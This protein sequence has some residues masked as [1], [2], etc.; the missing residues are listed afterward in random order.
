MTEPAQT[1]APEDESA[2]LAAVVH[3][4]RIT[5]ALAV[6]AALAYVVPGL[7]RFRIWAPGEPP[8][9]AG[10]FQ[11]RSAEL[12]GLAGSSV[13]SE[14]TTRQR[15]REELGE[16]VAS[17][18]GGDAEPTSARE[19]PL[20]SVNPSEYEGITQRIEDPTGRGMRPFYE[21][22]TATAE[23]RE[24]A[25]TRVAHYGDSSIATDLITHTVR[26]R[27]QQR[28]GDGGHGFVLIARGY[29][30][31]RHRDLTHVT[32]GNWRVYEVTRAMLG[33]GHYGYG[34]IAVRG[35]SG[36]RA[37]FGT[38][39][40]APVGTRVSR[41]DLYYRAHQRGGRAELRVDGGEPRL[42]DTA[43]ETTEDRV[44]SVTVPDGAHELELRHAG[45]LLHLYGMALE[46]EGPGVVY[47]SLGLVGARANRLLNFDGE[48]VRAQIAQRG[49][50]LV[51]LG[52][53][54]NESSDSISEDKY[55]DEFVRVIR[56]MRGAREDLGCLIVAPLDQAERVG[57][58]I[59]TMRAIPRIVAAQ[60]RAA[61]D[62]GCGFYDTWQAMGGEGAMRRW[63]RAHPR[64]AMG[65][66][67][68]A[69]PAGYEI[70]GNMLYKALLAGFADYLEGRQRAEVRPAR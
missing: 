21:A 8:L 13:E 37:R 56:H 44:E 54:G 19:G 55:Y 24:G 18:L 43:S 48:H 14:E 28:F 36:A 2:T 33:D 65:D 9:F 30:P 64:L 6:C 47:D 27:L 26:R 58:G 63:Y 29:L 50:D 7:E 66:F 53:G 23:Q 15:L 60:R 51:V 25:L 31:Y 11:I 20:T 32:I 40:E 41:F 4:A 5:A 35:S 34:G 45:G 42:L 3:L 10:L 69:T 38:D 61:R 59:R 49:T 17:N 16:S 57:S 62:E 70:I 1:R 67:R 12:P 68:H 39:P 46:R 52:F 22:L